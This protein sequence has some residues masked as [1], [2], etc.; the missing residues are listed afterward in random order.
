MIQKKTTHCTRL[1]Q[2]FWRLRAYKFFWH[3]KSQ[4][5]TTQNKKNKKTKHCVKHRREQHGVQAR[6]Q[7]KHGVQARRQEKHVGSCWK[8]VKIFAAAC[9]CAC[10]PRLLCFGVL[11]RHGC[12]VSVCLHATFQHLPVHKLVCTY[13]CI[14]AGRVP[15]TQHYPGVDW[16][17]YFGQESVQSTI[18]ILTFL[19]YVVRNLRT[20]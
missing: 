4:K 6:R 3:E 17:S 16:A 11:A 10:T 5:R 14:S 19:S 1:I 8:H 9:Q 7:E 18:L 15:V 20:Y 2:M 12:Y 13:M